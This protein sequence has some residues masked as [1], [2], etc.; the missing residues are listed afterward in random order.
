MAY[1]TKT[2]ISAIS[3][4]IVKSKTLK[5]AYNAVQKMGNVEGV[6]IPPY[7]EA[8]KEHEEESRTD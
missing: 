3:Q 2:T 7:D 1:E 5:E 6:F 8:L 4:L